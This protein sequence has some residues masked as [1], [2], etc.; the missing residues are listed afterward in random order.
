MFPRDQI[1]GNNSGG[2]CVA[3]TGLRK[4]RPRRRRWQRNMIPRY[5]KWQQRCQLSKQKIQRVIVNIY[6][7]WRSTTSERLWRR[8][9]RCVY[10]QPE[11]LTMITEASIEEAE[12]TVLLSERLQRQTG[13]CIYGQRVLIT[14]TAALEDLDGEKG[15]SDD[16]GGIGRWRGIY[17]ASVG[18]ETTPETAEARR[19]AQGIYDNNGGFE[20]VKWGVER[21]RRARWLQQQQRMRQQM[22]DDASKGS[23]MMMEA[24]VNKRWAWW[25][26]NNNGV[27]LFLDLRLITLTL[28]SLCLVTIS[29][30]YCFRHIPFFGFDAW[31][32]ISTAIMQKVF[33]YQIYTNLAYVPPTY[34]RVKKLRV[35]IINKDVHKSLGRNNGNENPICS[36]NDSYN[37]TPGPLQLQTN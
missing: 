7:E 9:R 13:R 8:R 11:V 30:W 37:K 20:G 23:K 19:Q 31:N 26:G 4:W 22:I 1:F 28:S 27:L 25:I 18:L 16:D 15:I 5:I 34:I 14:T 32:T 21:G 2:C 36:R 24:A 10:G 12:N 17:D 35:L 29:F 33:L 6:D 3:M